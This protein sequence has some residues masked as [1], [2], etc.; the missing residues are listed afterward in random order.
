MSA[1]P[2]SS[3]ATNQSEGPQSI[4]D[5]MN[6]FQIPSYESERLAGFFRDYDTIM[7]HIQHGF[8]QTIDVACD[9][10]ELQQSDMITPLESDMQTYIDLEHQLQEQKTI[11]DELQ[12]G[13]CDQRLKGDIMK[14]YT[15]KWEKNMRKYSNMPAKRKYYNHEQYNSFK[16]IIWNVNHP[17]EP[18]PPL[19]EEDGR[20]KDDDIVIGA[21][22]LALKCPLTTTWF[23]EPLTSKLCKHTFSKAAIMALLKRSHGSVE[24]P[25]PGCGKLIDQ[26]VLYED[27]LMERR[28]ARQQALEASSSHTEFYDVE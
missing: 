10:E 8:K 27:T 3:S 11:I 17:D 14:E 21:T 7:S 15:K 22:K 4:T 18:M 19:G 26:R 13:V 23:E 12:R 28:V 20:A 2:S 5:I 6:N 9:L 24:C 1:T 25:I 16:Q